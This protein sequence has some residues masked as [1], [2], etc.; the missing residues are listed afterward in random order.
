MVLE[1]VARKELV[2]RH[3]RRE[4]IPSLRG[5]VDYAIY[6]TEGTYDFGYD[7]GDGEHQS[8]RQESRDDTGL[9]TGLYGYIQQD[10]TLHVVKYEADERGYRWTTS[11]YRPVPSIPVKRPPPPKTQL[12]RPLIVGPIPAPLP[13]LRR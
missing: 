5:R 6:Y 11:N 2:A 3:G 1:C 10:G 12:R 13:R 4:Q 8:F 9:V 7:T